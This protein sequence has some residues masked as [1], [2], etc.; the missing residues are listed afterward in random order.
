MKKYALAALLLG[1][2]T[3]GFTSCE[4]LTMAGLNPFE[5]KMTVMATCVSAPAP[6]FYEGGDSISFGKGRGRTTLTTRP[7]WSQNITVRTKQG[8][9]CSGTITLSTPYDRV[10]KGQRELAVIGVMSGKL[11]TFGGR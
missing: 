2:V 7:S 6:Q 11:Y 9:L 3:A 10:H 8:R 1:S 4:T 5:E